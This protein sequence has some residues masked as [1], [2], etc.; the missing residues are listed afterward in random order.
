MLGHDGSLFIHRLV[1]CDVHRSVLNNIGYVSLHNN[2][3]LY[4]NYSNNMIILVLWYVRAGG[5]SLDQG[6]ECHL[7]LIETSDT[8]LLSSTPLCST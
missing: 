7:Q 6:V 8:L 4:N 2:V 5:S 1:P 3:L